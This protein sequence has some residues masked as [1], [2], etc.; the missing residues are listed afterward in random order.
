MTAF[1][2]K[3]NS[4]L[5]K[6]A[7]I[8]LISLIF[9]LKTYIL[10]IYKNFL[11]KKEKKKKKKLQNAKTFIQLYTNFFYINFSK[12]SLISSNISPS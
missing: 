9:T 8:A 6:K 1:F 3:K 12:T 11:I 2:F 5:Q 10:L 4:H 7:V